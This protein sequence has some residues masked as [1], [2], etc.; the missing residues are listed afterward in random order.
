MPTPSTLAD[1]WASY[2]QRV[3]PPGES[4]AAIKNHQFAFYGGASYVLT[5]LEA[6]GGAD[7]SFQEG[8]EIIQGLNQELH[9][10]AAAEGARMK[11]RR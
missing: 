11:P 9:L 3:I 5:L 8:V 7:V 10:F 6:I 1:M 2:A 4:A